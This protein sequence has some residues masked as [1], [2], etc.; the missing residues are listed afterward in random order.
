MSVL[1]IADMNETFIQELTFWKPCTFSVK[2]Y[3]NQR[4]DDRNYNQ[5]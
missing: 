1:F 5:T 2:Y 4:F 3:K